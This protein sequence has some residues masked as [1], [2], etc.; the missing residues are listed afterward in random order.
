[1]RSTG[2][3]TA[4]VSAKRKAVSRKVTFQSYICT[5]VWP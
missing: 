3:L 1:M 2:S 4:S 5:G